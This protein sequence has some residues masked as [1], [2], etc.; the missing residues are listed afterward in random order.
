ME[1]EWSENMCVYWCVCVCVSCSCAVYQPLAYPLGQKGGQT[2][3]KGNTS[4]RE[5]EINKAVVLYWSN[6]GKY[7]FYI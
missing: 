4:M 3:A 1:M 6:T 2:S 7:W 5:R